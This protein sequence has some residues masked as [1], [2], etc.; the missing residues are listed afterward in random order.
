MQ[1][2]KVEGP[3]KGMGDA[4]DLEVREDLS[5]AAEL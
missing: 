4:S 2:I 5:K 1:K 3:R